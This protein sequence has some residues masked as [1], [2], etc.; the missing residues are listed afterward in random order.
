[1]GM[2]GKKLE[3]KVDQL[4]RYL[5]SAMVDEGNL[6]DDDIY[7][8]KHIKRLILDDEV[9]SKDIVKLI[10]KA[11]FNYNLKILPLKMLIMLLEKERNLKLKKKNVTAKFIASIITCREDIY[12]LLPSCGDIR[13][14]PIQFRK[15]IELGAIKISK[16]FPPID[17]NVSVLINT[18]SG[19]CDR[20]DTICKFLFVLKEISKNLDLYLFN[21][22]TIELIPSEL[23]GIKFY[24]TVN[25]NITKFFAYT[26]DKAYANRAIEG[27]RLYEL[28]E[29]K[30]R[31]LMIVITQDQQ[32]STLD[33]NR[34]EHEELIVINIKSLK[35]EIIYGKGILYLQGWSNNYIEFINKYLNYLDENWECP[36]NIKDMNES[37]AKRYSKESGLDN[38]VKQYI[39]VLKDKSVKKFTVDNKGISV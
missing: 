20:K 12:N 27:V 13:A 10:N 18:S 11:K 17:K 30:K 21:D 7:V 34:G 15:G 25:D 24:N 39:D 31:E 8:R 37:D 1:M 38:F 26:Q 23:H 4:E 3:N 9:S 28:K 16:E 22:Q 14:L 36:E 29:H 32:Y 2:H 5:L 33:W 35:N 6:Y 19:I